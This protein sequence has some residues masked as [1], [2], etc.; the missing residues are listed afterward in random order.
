MNDESKKIVVSGEGANSEL[1]AKT[2]FVEFV[3]LHPELLAVDFLKKAKN[4][5][6]G[7]AKDFVVEGNQEGVAVLLKVNS[8]EKNPEFK[9]KAAHSYLKRLMRLI[10]DKTEFPDNAKYVAE[11]MGIFSGIVK[12]FPDRTPQYFS[13]YEVDADLTVIAG[14]TLD[15]TPKKYYW[16]DAS[17]EKYQDEI[18]PIILFALE[19][20]ARGENIPAEFNEL[21]D[22]YAKSQGT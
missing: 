17:I 18:E 21:K 6:K 2:A 12:L 9:T 8:T 19:R 20:H 10:E 4:V 11:V 22:L 7:F 3:K 13:S 14:Q 15:G 5:Y 1:K 16:A